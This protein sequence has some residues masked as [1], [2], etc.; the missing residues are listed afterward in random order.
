MTELKMKKDYFM[1]HH[2]FLLVSFSHSAQVHTVHGEQSR[3]LRLKCREKH[4][5]RTVWYGQRCSQ[6]PFIIVAVIGSDQP[7]FHP[8]FIRGSESNFNIAWDAN[9]ASVSLEIK[10]F[11]D[12][13]QGFYYCSVGDEAYTIIGSG[14]TVTLKETANTPTQAPATLIVHEEKE[15]W[16]WHTVAIW[17]V[18]CFTVSGIALWGIYEIQKQPR[19]K[20]KHKGVYTTVYYT[21][22]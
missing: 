10:N 6:L 20:K 14:Y 21:S 7:P 3:E 18:I 9:A 12:S 17:P 11:S 4:A 16:Q 2:I 8:V 22:S 13:D 1:C 5:D 19:S 15:S